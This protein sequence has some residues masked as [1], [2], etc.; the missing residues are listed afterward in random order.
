MP[1]NLL[2]VPCG[3]RTARAARPL[4]RDSNT[5]VNRQQQAT[6][7]QVMTAAS[8]TT[9]PIDELQQ[10][11]L[12]AGHQVVNAN[13]EKTLAEAVLAVKPEALCLVVA[14]PDSQLFDELAAIGREHPIPLVLF[15]RDGSDDTIQRA[16]KAQI[17]AYVVDGLRPERVDSLLKLA[18]ARHQAQQA[19]NAE[20][21]KAKRDLE[22]RKLI[23]R[24][25][26]I[27]IESR[28]ISENEAY[29]TL[30]KLA[31]ERNQRLSQV[32]ADL[33]AMAKVLN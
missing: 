15:A 8:G 16:I 21:N 18:S 25:K 19:V 9:A 5:P 13:P 22:D 26:G 23:D 28:N 11:L 1:D 31:M 14:Y 12:R 7:M 6:T 3:A 17:H 24:A 20:L 2:A 4:H 10:A 30:R 33:I 32:A 29:H 27:L